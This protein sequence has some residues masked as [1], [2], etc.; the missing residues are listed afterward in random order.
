MS[1][2]KDGQAMKQF[3]EFLFAVSAITPTITALLFEGGNMVLKRAI[4]VFV[5]CAVVFFFSLTYL[6][7]QSKKGGK[8]NN[9]RSSKTY[10]AQS[11]WYR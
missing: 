9:G 7:K 2:G 1:I 11:R 8:H 10:E 5:I 6:Y 4:I 3:I